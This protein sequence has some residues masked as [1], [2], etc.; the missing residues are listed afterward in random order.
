[1]WGQ[2]LPTPVGA[3]QEASPSVEAGGLRSSLRSQTQWSLVGDKPAEQRGAGEMGRGVGGWGVGWE[4]S[5]HKRPQSLLLPPGQRF[6]CGGKKKRRWVLH[7]FKAASS[8]L[9]ILVLSAE[10]AGVSARTPSQ[11]SHIA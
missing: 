9:P 11:L 1:M 8:L 10:R 5:S 7:G 4:G 6:H 3:G 2:C